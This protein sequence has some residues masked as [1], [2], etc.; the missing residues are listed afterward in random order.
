MATPGLVASDVVDVYL[1]AL[2]IEH[3]LTLV[4][5]DQGY[6]APDRPMWHTS[7]RMQISA[8][9]TNVP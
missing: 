6:V 7:T 3:G 9:I 2:A 4:T 5:H 1:A 8:Y